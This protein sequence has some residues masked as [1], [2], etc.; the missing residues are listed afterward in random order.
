MVIAVKVGIAPVGQF[1]QTLQLMEIYVQLVFSVPKEVL[2][3]FLVFL[4]STVAR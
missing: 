2:F 1:Y 4:V 3:L